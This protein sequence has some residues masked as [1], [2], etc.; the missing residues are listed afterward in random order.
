MSEQSV[1]LIRKGFEH[2]T[3]TGEPDWETLDPEIEV[4]DHDIPDAGVYRGHSGFLKWLEDWGDPWESFSMEPER[5]VGAGDQVVVIF[6]MT[7]KGR[8]SGVE[9]KRRDGM[10]WTIREGRTVRLDYYNSDSQAL[11]AAGVRE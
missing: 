8:G 6:Q 4:Y 5:F 10:V 9:I 3:R 2:F 7:A 11:E 1:E